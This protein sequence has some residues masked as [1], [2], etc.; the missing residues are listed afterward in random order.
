MG[1]INAVSFTFKGTNKPLSGF[2]MILSH[3]SRLHRKNT[4]NIKIKD[5]SPTTGK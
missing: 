1:H 3:K 4:T 5:V 2:E